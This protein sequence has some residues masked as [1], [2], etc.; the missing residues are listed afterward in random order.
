VSQTDTQNPRSVYGDAML[1]LDDARTLLG[2]H[3]PSVF[4]APNVGAVEAWQ[5]FVRSAPDLASAM[6]ETARAN[7][8]HCAIKQRAAAAV[9]DRFGARVAARLGFFAVAFDVRALVRYKLLSGGVPSN[10]S[11]FQQALLAKQQYDDDMMLALAEDGFPTPPTLLTC[12]YRLTPD[13]QLRSVE[14]RCDYDGKMVWRWPIYGREADGG[15]VMEPLPL[16]NMPG[17][18]PA[19]VRST[20]KADRRGAQEA[21]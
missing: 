19:R 14:V 10:V 20:R 9:E 1:M 4:V 7:V 21:P 8:I 5:D 11:T 6:D 12:G 13:S 3:A 2:P 18:V 17:P 15:T 16:P